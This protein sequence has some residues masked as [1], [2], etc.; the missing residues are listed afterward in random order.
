MAD[1]LLIHGAAHGAWCWRDVIPA[2]AALGHSARAIDLPGHG[3][4]TTP[5][6]AVTLDKYR[7]AVLGALGPQNAGK[8]VLVGHSMGGYPITAAAAMAPDRVAGL[9]YVCA[10][11]PW[12][13]H[14]LAQ[15]RMRAPRQPLL[16]AIRMTEDRLG[17]TADPAMIPDL[18]YH[19][20]P[21]ETV[22][23]A[24]DRLC[25]QAVAPTSVPVTLTE[26]LASVPRAYVRCSD[27]RTIPPEFQATMT[28]GWPADSVV[29]MATSHSPF[30]AAPG[31]LAGHIDRFVK[32][33]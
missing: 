29:D 17:W 28:A 18:F 6:A 22:A 32:G 1:I 24:M 19:D 16:P 21:P 7:D 27:D 23:F 9:V 13:D 4:D 11:V 31:V 2:L 20:C 33:F 12:P 3:A 15:M 26:G 8:T 25:V 14:S 5:Y 30:F 10:Y